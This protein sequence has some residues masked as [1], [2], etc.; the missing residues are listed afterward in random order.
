MQPAP[1]G[2]AQRRIRLR[3]GNS[4][5]SP[6]V[7]RFPCTMHSSKSTFFARITISLV[8]F[9]FFVFTL[10]VLYFLSL[11]G[12]HKQVKYCG[13]FSGVNYDQYTRVGNLL[14]WFFPNSMLHQPLR[15]RVQINDGLLCTTRNQGLQWRFGKD[16]YHSFS[17]SIYRIIHTIHTY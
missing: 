9:P 14:N 13:E 17:F 4:K 15:F 8:V 10:T 3:V 11:V 2:T 16:C 7:V 5:H 1:Q 12:G 6:A